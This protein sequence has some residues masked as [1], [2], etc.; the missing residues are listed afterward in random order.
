MLSSDLSSVPTRLQKELNKLMHEGLPIITLK[1]KITKYG[2]KAVTSKG[3]SR[4]FSQLQKLIVH[5]DDKSTNSASRHAKF[6]CNEAELNHYS[7]VYGS[8]KYL[9]EVN[10]SH[11]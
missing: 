9:L 4:V 10:S 5:K 11:T 7:I 2:Y 6:L 8:P 3:Y 1:F